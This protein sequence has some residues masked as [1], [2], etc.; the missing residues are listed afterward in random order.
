MLYT[1][2]PFVLVNLLALYYHPILATIGLIIYLILGC[3]VIGPLTYEA[4]FYSIYP[5]QKDYNKFTPLLKNK[6]VLVTGAN[7]GIGSGIVKELVSHGA[8]VIIACR[9]QLQQTVTKLKVFASKTKHS[10]VKIQGFEIDL[11]NFESYLSFFKQ[12]KSENIKIDILC[13]NAGMTIHPARETKDG[14]DM[15]LFVNFL[16]NVILTKYFI[17]LNLFNENGST[18]PRIV[19]TSSDTHRWQKYHDFGKKYNYS[20]TGQVSHYAETKMWNQMLINYLVERYKNKI[21]CYGHCPGPVFSE[22]ARHAP[23]YMRLFAYAF[24]GILFQGVDR[25][26]RHIVYSCMQPREIYKS[27]TYHWMQH[28]VSLSKDSLDKRYIGELM[29]HAY[30]IVTELELKYGTVN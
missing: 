25:G 24:M 30:K 13:L 3:M 18:L 17:K 9:S 4:C 10:N 19:S 5:A 21:D 16:A 2:V 29:E 12:L 7:R 26:G 6:T 22:I 11:S 27:G 1:F 15:M 14:I 8:N 23:M 20:L 28:D